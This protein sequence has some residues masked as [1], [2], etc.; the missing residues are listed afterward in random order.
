MSD[1]LCAR[2]SDSTDLIKKIVKRKKDRS[3]GRGR[4]AKNGK[5]KTTKK[6]PEKKNNPSLLE[7][8]RVRVM[9][10]AHPS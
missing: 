6:K 2:A 5:H 8:T 7:I 1:G 4:E 10:T 3:R 9:K